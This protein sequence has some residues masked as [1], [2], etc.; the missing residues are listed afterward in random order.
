M[1]LNANC[2]S[3]AP[4]LALAKR[5]CS[6]R[7]PWLL[8]LGWVGW[9]KATK[10]WLTAGFP[11]SCVVW[12]KQN[13]THIE[14]W[15]GFFSIYLGLWQGSWQSFR[16]CNLFPLELLKTTVLATVVWP[17]MSQTGLQGYTVVCNAAISACESGQQWRHAF[18]Q[19]SMIWWSGSGDG[20]ECLE[21]TLIHSQHVE[22]CRNMNIIE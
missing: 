3:G 5:Q 7:W 10:L 11:R 2:L 13:K 16:R 8:L 17:R 22:I 19:G 9:K 14:T 15:H 1:V 21:P 18:R 4:L 20:W 6:G 12:R